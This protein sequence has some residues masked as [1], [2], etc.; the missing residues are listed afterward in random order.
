MLVC[1]SYISK[2]YVR[3]N[4]GYI[5]IIIYIYVY[6]RAIWKDMFTFMMTSKLGCDDFICRIMYSL[7]S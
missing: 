5:Y 4:Y 6:I 1:N 2:K 3:I 7:M